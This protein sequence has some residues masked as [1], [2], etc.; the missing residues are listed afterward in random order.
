MYFCTRRCF[1]IFFR[2]PAEP[3]LQTRPNSG[4]VRRTYVACCCRRSKDDRI[5]SSITAHSF[6]KRRY[7]RQLLQHLNN[8]KDEE[9]VLHYLKKNIVY[10]QDGIVAINKPPGLGVSGKV[11]EDDESSPLTLSS[12]MSQVADFTD[13][14]S[15]EIAQG[16]E[17]EASGLLLLAENRMAAKK[18]QSKIKEARNRRQFIKT[19]RSIVCGIPETK[20]GVSKMYLGSDV[21]G[22]INMTVGRHNPSGR[23]IR[24]GDVW[25]AETKYRVIS[26]NK[27]LGCA[28]IEL[29]PLRVK[30]HQLQVQMVND[31]CP[32]LGDHTYSHQVQ[33][34]LGKPI[35]MDPHQ[36][37]G[38]HNIQV[39]SPGIRK[40]LA[41]TRPQVSLLPLFL[42]LHHVVLPEWAGHQDVTITAPLPSH[43]TRALKE[44][45]LRS[46]EDV[47]QLAG[48]AS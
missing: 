8:S 24:D 14:P 38:V 32:I 16:L 46:S 43:F 2:R 33:T 9:A 23:Q 41:M 28:F 1:A 37:L 19:Y 3:L 25:S 15:A 44:L 47:K 39:L 29:Q 13:C 30:R 48:S 20:I 26:E 45:G 42:H 34:I 5:Q 12:M 6:A 10:Q 7:H 31:L 36:A 17:K 4:A 27:E 40:A 11:N 22:G 18:L 21:I 35:L